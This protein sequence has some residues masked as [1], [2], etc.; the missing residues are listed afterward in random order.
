MASKKLSALLEFGAKASASVA[1]ATSFTQKRI[2]GL[3]DA[4]K[5]NTKKQA[6]L[7]KEMRKQERQ[8]KATGA[9]YLK[10]KHDLDA[11]ERS[12]KRLEKQQRRLRR[13]NRAVR[14][15][16]RAIGRIG[17]GVLRGIGIGA[18]AA[19]TGLGKL[20]T[21]TAAYGDELAKTSR[22][23]GISS[24]S[25]E[26][27]RFIAE[28]QGVSNE[29]LQKGLDKM[30]IALGEAA[31]T[32][33]GPYAQAFRALGIDQKKFRALKPEDQLKRM[34]T[35]MNG[36]KD[37][38]ERTHK[39][40]LLFGQRGLDML[41]I[42][43]AGADGIQALGDQF[44][45]LGGAM[46]E[47]GTKSAEAFT[48][49]LTNLKQ[50][51]GASLHKLGGSILPQVNGALDDLMTS[52]KSSDID[53]KSIG[54]TIGVMVGGVIWAVKWLAKF[55][56]WL[57]RVGGWLGDHAAQVAMLFGGKSF[58]TTNSTGLPPPSQGV[59]ANG[60]SAGNVTINQTVNA[61][62]GMTEDQLLAAAARQNQQAALASY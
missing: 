26:K 5:A 19:V 1:R 36:L 7:R 20:I 49:K 62:P 8:G 54:Q 28:R 47:K 34:A 39:A 58:N 3:G 59:L 56:G 32:A 24:A 41:K 55:V 13:A 31:R 42:T 4:I 11:I 27:L 46:G 51:V 9:A 18:V 30:K 22:R 57:D 52:L 17:K 53:I 14:G 38:T 45:E 43:E 29:V 15:S 48:D 44:D 25:L 50:A 10:M 60:Q 21:S 23:M 40:Y 37:D 16:F 2:N 61:S 35:A 33:N 12:S 6:A